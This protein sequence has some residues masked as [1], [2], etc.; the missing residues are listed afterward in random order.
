MWAWCSAELFMMVQCCMFLQ[1]PWSPADTAEQVVERHKLAVVFKC[2]DVVRVVHSLLATRVDAMDSFV[3][4][5]NGSDFPL[6]NL[7]FGAC[8]FTPDA[9]NKT[10]LCVAI[11][12]HVVDL[13][14]LQAAGCFTGPILSQTDCFTKVPILLLI[15]DVCIAMQR[16]DRKLDNQDSHW[17]AA[18][19]AG[20]G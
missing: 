5:P 6:N 14:Q 16:H 12:E 2:I 1:E 4:V 7:P 18:T 13:G 9:S 20:Q 10:R 11:G 15:S 19:V 3:P 8:K 17:M